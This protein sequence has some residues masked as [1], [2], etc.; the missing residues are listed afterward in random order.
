MGYE[1]I[2]L[3]T[4]EIVNIQENKIKNL[5]DLSERM[6]TISHFNKGGCSH[7]EQKGDFANLIIITSQ[8][9]A[10]ALPESWVDYLISF[11]P[12]LFI[13]TMGEATTKAVQARGLAVGYTAPGGY[14]S[15]DLFKKILEYRENIINIPILILTGE[16]GRDFLAKALRERGAQVEVL[17]L[18]RRQCPEY[19]DAELEDIF[20]EGL[21]TLGA[22]LC[23]GPLNLS[24]LVTSTESLDNLLKII[25]KFSLFDLEAAL[26]LKQ[27]R[28][29]VPSGRVQRHALSKGFKWIVMAAC[30][31]DQEMMGATTHQQPFV[32]S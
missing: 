19:S 30:A 4:L 28:L 14:T 23:A 22:G 16:G 21:A 18:Y 3:P 26:D 13:M 32:L 17:P 7:S 29:I 25:S 27:K 12:S 11:S 2:V 8:N 10:R 31:H 6:R 24:I 1:P 20:T 9:A 5:K 15:E